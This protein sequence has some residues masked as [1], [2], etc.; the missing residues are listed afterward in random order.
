VSSEVADQAAPLVSIRYRGQHATEIFVPLDLAHP[1]QLR[2]AFEALYREEFGFLKEDSPCEVTGV[3]LK[4]REASDLDWSVVLRGLGEVWQK[5]H[6]PAV[7]RRES[8]C[9]G[10]SGPCAVMHLDDVAGAPDGVAGPAVLEAPDSTIVIPPGW[11]ARV[12]DGVGVQ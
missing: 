10:Y 8:M 7:T 9:D 6:R 12:H 3:R 11:R 5:A 4:F 1:E 2:P